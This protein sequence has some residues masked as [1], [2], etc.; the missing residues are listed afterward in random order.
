[1]M[2]F[3]RMTFSAVGEP[4]E[5][6]FGSIEGADTYEDITPSALKELLHSR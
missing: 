1:M 3:F 4:T 2:T 5:F 6:Q